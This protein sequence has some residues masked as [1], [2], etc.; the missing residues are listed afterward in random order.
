VLESTCIARKSPRI[1]KDILNA[2]Q[3]FC[4]WMSRLWFRRMQGQGTVVVAEGGP[5]YK[6]KTSLG[7]T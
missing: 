2:L 1:N 3:P 4:S 5:T 7:N 6:F